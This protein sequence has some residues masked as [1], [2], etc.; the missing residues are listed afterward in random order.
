[1]QRG[2]PYNELS[3]E[4]KRERRH[5]SKVVL[6]AERQAKLAVAE[7]EREKA[8]LEAETADIKEQRDKA[9]KD[10]KTAQS[11]A[12]AKLFKPG[13]YKKEQ[14]DKLKKAAFNAG[15]DKALETILEVAKLK[16]NTKPTAELLGQRY[17]SLWDSNKN[18]AKE[19]KDKDKI[20][21]EKT[22]E[23]DGLKVKVTQ[24]TEQVKNLKYRLTLVDDDAVSQLRTSL[25][26]ART[27][28]DNT[29]S[30]LRSL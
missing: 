5:K 30:E 26:E 19:V 10:L 7:A 17:R 18:L 8:E 14:E 9:Q 21:S 29:K 3:D 12:F 1:M 15:F 27:E 23:I 4:E 13:K 22:A 28:A 25:K 11:G 24:L 16:W 20:I 2:I 6:E